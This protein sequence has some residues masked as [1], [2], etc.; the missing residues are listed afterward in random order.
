MNVTIPPSSKSDKYLTRFKTSVYEWPTNGIQGDGRRDC[1]YCRR[2]GYNI[3][4]DCVALNN[5]EASYYLLSPQLM[6]TS[7]QIGIQNLK[8]RLLLL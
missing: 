6:K 7:Y 1:Y 4:Q 3:Q 8:H 5:N 2:D